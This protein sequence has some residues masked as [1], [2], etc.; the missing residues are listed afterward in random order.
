MR[1]LVTKAFNSPTLMTMGGFAAKSLS[2]AVMLLVLRTLPETDIQLW[3][4]F[5]FLISLQN[6]ADF[7]FS[8]SVARVFSYAF[9]GAKR[10]EEYTKLSTE[11]TGIPNWQ[12]IGQIYATLQRVYQKLN[13]I[14]F[15]AMLTVGTALVYKPIE[16]SVHSWHGWY[17]WSIILFVSFFYVRGNIFVAYLE[18][19]GK[20][21]TLRRWEMG[22]HL[23]NVFS[24]LLI[25]WLNGEILPL[26]ASNQ[27][28][29]L[30]NVLRNRYLS[31][32]V[33]EGKLAD[34]KHQPADRVIYRLVFSRSWKSA[35]GQLFNVGITQITALFYGLVGQTSSVV[36]YQFSL[37]ILQIISEF[38]RAPFY[39]QIPFYNMLVARNELQ[40]L[41]QKATRSMRL[42]V[43]F[44]TVGV[45]GTGL[46][47]PAVL[48]LLESNASLATPDLWALLALG[49]F[50]ERYGALH[51]QLYTTTNHV[52]WHIT[53]VIAGSL[54]L[55][56]LASSYSFWGVYAFPAAFLVSNFGFYLWYNASHVYRTFPIQFWK[57]ESRVSFIPFILLLV[58]L[59][60]TLAGL[61]T[62]Q[63]FF[64]F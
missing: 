43:W 21:A 12:L 40:T 28:W 52:L 23:L 20:V 63:D 17:A 15:A 51:L 1:T 37:R 49:M 31:H 39:S 45:V 61:P 64:Y 44:Y 62:P 19:V 29:L 22:F 50:A 54:F 8:P 25:L 3:L 10:L 24:S 6:L 5:S 26:V 55:L 16:Q 59:A 41:V 48:V 9:G 35:M 58:Y 30:A 11:N 13:L 56:T 27:F 53:N 7:G 47:L 38:S 4:S 42:S 46:F 36:S 14:A 60:I 33:Y 57:F 34:A 18:G 32:R 2:I